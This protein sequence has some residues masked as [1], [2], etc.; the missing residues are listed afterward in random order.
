MGWLSNLF[1][2]KTKKSSQEVG[3]KRRAVVAEGPKPKTPVGTPPRSG[4][5]NAR[6]SADDPRVSGW[7]NWNICGWVDVVGVQFYREDAVWAFRSAKEGDTFELVREPTNPHDTNAIKVLYR[8]RHVGFIDRDL[9]AYAAESFPQ[10]MPVKAGYVN[11]WRGDADFVRLT[12]QPL[13]P[14]VKSRKQNGWEIVK[15]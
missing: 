7:V 8:G 14:N 13:M 3:S 5:G 10:E 1:G 6:Q 9:A 15:R 12:I 11:G 4:A 2:G